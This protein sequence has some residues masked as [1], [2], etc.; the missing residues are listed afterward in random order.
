MFNWCIG[1]H[2]ACLMNRLA[3]KRNTLN[4]SQDALAKHLGWRQSRIGNYEAGRTPSLCDCRKIVSVLNSLGCKC[5][6]DDVFPPSEQEIN[7]A[8]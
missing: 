6:I 4:I 1:K 3:E 7:N 2:E 8:A 5:T